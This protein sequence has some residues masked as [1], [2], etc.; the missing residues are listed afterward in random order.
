MSSDPTLSPTVAGPRPPS[1]PRSPLGRAIHRFLDDPSSGRNVLIVIVVAN[2]TTIVIGGLAVWIFDRAE[3]DELTEALWYSLQTVTTV[4]Y[5][6]VTPTETVGRF[7][8][9][10]IMLLGIAFLSVTTAWITSTFLDARQA[11]RRVASDA[12]EAARWNNLEARL[13][14]LTAQLERLEGAGR[15]RA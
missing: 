14:A 7:V 5:G 8:G 2:L 6:D 10:V 9:A 11:E 13:D 1:R 3:F 4:G 15:G 12:E